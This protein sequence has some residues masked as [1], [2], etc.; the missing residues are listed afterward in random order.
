VTDKK[1]TYAQKDFEIKSLLRTAQTLTEALPYLQEFSG[2]TFVIKY[3]GHAMGDEKLAK[4]F[5]R[6][7]VLIKQVGINPLIVHGGGPQIAKMLQRLNIKTEVV[8]GLRVTDSETVQIVEMV[9]AGSINK[10]V[11]TAIND[12]GGTAVGISGK[13]GKLIQARKLQH[14]RK[15]D[16]NIE[17]VLD[18]GFVGEPY[19]VNTE[20]IDTLVESH[21]IPV[22][23]PLGI[24]ENGITYNINA[25]TAAG[26]IAGAIG[27]TRLLMLTD[28]SG[29]L[30]KSGKIL[31]NIT[32]RQ[33]RTMIKN[34]V[35]S[36][37]M[38]PKIETCL[39]AVKQGVEAA[40]IMD[41]RVPHALLLEI[42]TEHG[43]GTMIRRK[44]S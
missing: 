2:K 8:D 40:V 15:T 30:D 33:A 22:I 37:G 11:V 3:G 44:P 7:I 23:A 20:V 39:D 32:A 13:D 14:K 26:A 34:S 42:F 1:N 19:A 38:I 17:K 10:E 9:L 24:G 21:M 29:I 6:D 4:Q 27:A 36:G 41:G 43:A 12:A 18:L 28:V 25:D 35:I 5:A 16:S 31:T